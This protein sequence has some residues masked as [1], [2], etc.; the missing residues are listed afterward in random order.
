MTFEFIDFLNSSHLMNN[1]PGKG[2]VAVF[3]LAFS[4]STV[5]T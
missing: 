5:I 4:K 3:K 1:V 2:S